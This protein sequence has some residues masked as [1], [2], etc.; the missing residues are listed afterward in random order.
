MNKIVVIA[1]LF[2]AAVS[3]A[4]V[5]IKDPDV[6]PGSLN[7]KTMPVKPDRFHMG[8]Y[9]IREPAA[10]LSE[11]YTESDVIDIRSGL[12]FHPFIAMVGEAFANHYSVEISPDDIWLLILD[13]TR[14]HVSANR[15]ALKKKFVLPKADTALVVRNDSLR[16]TSSAEEWDKTTFA[17]FDSL[18]S[19]LPPKTMDA[20]NA[21]FSTTTAIHANVAKAMILSVASEYYSYEFSTL[22]G[23]PEILVKGEKEDWIL[24]KKK[25]NQ[26]VKELNMGWWAKEVNPILD[27]FIAA[28]DGNIKMEF[29]RG[30]YKY[31]SAGENS[32]AIGGINGWLNRF[33]PYNAVNPWKGNKPKRRTDWKS[34]MKENDLPRGT[35][36][37]TIR[38]KMSAETTSLNFQMGFMGVHLDKEHQRLKAVH[39]H[40]LVMPSR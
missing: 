1:A 7:Y 35:S 33:F 36:Y 20:F 12:I 34:P 8:L 16:V 31:L 19:K 2:F 39:G 26:L 6:K 30:I 3:F 29:W 37:I 21:S 28:Y 5:S 23:I 27:Q 14:I 18:G 13:G 4:D 32:G 25:Y 22:C 40:A 9:E 24:L 10:I 15:E 38:W 17:L 11:S